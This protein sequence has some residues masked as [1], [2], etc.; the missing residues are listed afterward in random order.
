MAVLQKTNDLLR[1][2]EI[3][4]QEGLQIAKFDKLKATKEW[5]DNWRQDNGVGPNVTPSKDIVPFKWMHPYLKKVESQGLQIA[6]LNMWPTLEGIGIK[7]PKDDSDYGEASGPNKKELE[8]RG[9]SNL[10]IRQLQNI[11]GGPS[12]DIDPTGHKGAQKKTKIYNKATQ[13]SGSEKEWLQKTGPQL[14]LRL[15]GIYDG[16]PNSNDL[17]IEKAVKKWGKDKDGK[18]IDKDR[19]IK[20]LLIKSA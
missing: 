20:A 9:W 8:D 2:Y 13:G 1:S 18:Y 15:A 5:V 14:P 11:A 4:K 6:D 3:G 16:I 17:R 7:I 12:F 10:M 19:L